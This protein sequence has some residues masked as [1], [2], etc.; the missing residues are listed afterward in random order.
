[1]S[2]LKPFPVHRIPKPR[3]LPERK[4][5]TVCIAAILFDENRSPSI[6]TACDRKIALLGGWFSDETATK[7]SGIAPNWMAMFAGYTEET[8][9]MLKGVS[10][11]MKKLKANTFERVVDC[12]R[13]TYAKQRRKLIESDVLPDYDLRTY[14]EYAALR[15]SDRA[16]FLEVEAQV[17][18]AEENWELLF[19]GF[20]KD[21]VPHLFVISG[22][23]KVSYCDQQKRAA[24]GTGAPAALVWLAFLEY[25]NVINLGDA[26]Y[27]VLTSKFFAERASDVGE[28]TIA[29]YFEPD[30]DFTLI[31]PV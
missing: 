29:G 1:M 28:E 4:A 12:C 22:S 20:D 18:K 17:R 6:I 23:G 10:E 13:K 30:R 14:S 5:V 8:T 27:S 2:P 26:L 11:A 15:Q 19:A 21:R 31:L 16:F 25:G 9:Q 3:R 7:V 24:I